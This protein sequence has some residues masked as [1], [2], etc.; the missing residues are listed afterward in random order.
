MKK[1]VIFLFVFIAILG[2]VCAQ[3]ITFTLGSTKQQVLNVMGQPSKSTK[4]S[5]TE[6]W[7]YNY[8]TIEFKNG[9]FGI[10]NFKS[11]FKKDY[12]MQLFEFI[13][14]KMVKYFN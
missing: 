4:F 8:S 5:D 9:I 1:N 6:T 10:I 13:S 3:P 14:N 12:Q 7:Y 11:A 2:N